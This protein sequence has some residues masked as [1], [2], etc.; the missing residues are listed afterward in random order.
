M[1]L[2]IPSLGDCLKLT[3]PWRFDLYNEDRNQTLMDAM[4][5]TREIAWGDITSIPCEIPVGEILKV[6]RIY[7]RKGHDEFSSITFFWQGKRTQ[8]KVIECWGRTAKKPA[9]PVRFWA[10][11]E[12]AN[13]I[14]FE[15][16]KDL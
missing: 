3:A 4:G 12:D 14:E 15:L 10:K 5:D 6:D 16:V 7:I 2:Y 13:R 11:L 1:K 9:R 8:P